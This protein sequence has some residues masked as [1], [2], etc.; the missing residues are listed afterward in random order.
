MLCY[1]IFSTGNYLGS[2]LSVIGLTTSEDIRIK[3]TL[4]DEKLVAEDNKY[5]YI[6]TT[7]RTLL[8][9]SKDASIQITKP[10]ELMTFSGKSENWSVNVSVFYRDNTLWYSGVIRKTNSSNTV[11]IAYELPNLDKITLEHSKPTSDFYIFNKINSENFKKLTFIN[12]SWPSSDGSTK[13]EKIE[14]SVSVL[15]YG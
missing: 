11:K 2:T 15:D 9:V 1:I 7:S 12:L 3:N 14:L 13:K 4:V 8:E 10:N 5:L 6:S